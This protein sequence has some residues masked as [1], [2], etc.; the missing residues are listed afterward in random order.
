MAGRMELLLWNWRLALL[1]LWRAWARVLQAQSVGLPVESFG[2][3][4]NRAERTPLARMACS[5][6]SRM[7]APVLNSKGH[8]IPFALAPRDQLSV[9]V[10][11]VC[12]E[13]RH[14]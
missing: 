9:A 5:V 4:M 1:V 13:C 14:V 6:Q 7:Q 10:V 8:S 2:A 11:Q 3:M 12:R